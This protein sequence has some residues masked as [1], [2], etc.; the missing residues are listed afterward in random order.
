LL[1]NRLTLG[2]ATICAGLGLGFVAALGSAWWRGLDIDCGC[3][4]GGGGAGSGNIALALL[5]AAAILAAAVA[6]WVLTARRARR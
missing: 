2:A 5:R 6:L 3:F 4:G 1:L